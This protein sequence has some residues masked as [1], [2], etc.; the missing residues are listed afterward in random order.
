MMKNKKHR[1]MFLLFLA[2]FLALFGLGSASARNSD[3]KQLPQHT[4]RNGKIFGHH[5]RLEGYSNNHALWEQMRLQQAFC[6]KLG[7]PVNL[8]P[9]D[10][11]LK[12]MRYDIYYTENLKVIYRADGL[13]SISDDCELI[14]TK[15]GNEQISIGYA[16][17]GV[18]IINSQKKEADGYCKAFYPQTVSYEFGRAYMMPLHPLKKYT[19]SNTKNCKNII[20]EENYNNGDTIHHSRGDH[21]CILPRKEK[22]K[23]LE[24]QDSENT[25]LLLESAD[26]DYEIDGSYLKSTVVEQDIYIDK[27]ILFPH[28]YAADFVIKEITEDIQGD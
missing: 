3:V 14:N 22:W 15:P 16:G 7:K 12:P 11:K 13:I 26:N 1:L 4:E 2:P 21:V 27:K 20:F 5:V 6:V 18:C 9:A 19:A 10:T 28:L 8:P 17:V 23:T 24:F 25:G